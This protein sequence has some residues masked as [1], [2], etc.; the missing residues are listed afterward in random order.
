NDDLWQGLD[1]V[2]NP[3]PQGFRLPTEVEFES[4]RLTWDS[5][6]AQGAFNSPL[7]LTLTGARSRVSGQ[8]GNVGMFAGYRTSTLSGG[9]ARVMGISSTNA[10][11]GTRE[12]ADGNCVR[13][14]MNEVN[15]GDLNGDDSI[16]ILDI[17]LIVNMILANESNSIADYNSDGEV[18]ILDIVAIVQVIL[19]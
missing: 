12:R 13:C 4:E 17:I 8:I 16:D 5:N 18:N 7:K 2:N 3:C 9:S 15:L 11:M 10:F 6:D 19:N 1:G 14:I